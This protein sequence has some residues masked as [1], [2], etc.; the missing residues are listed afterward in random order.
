MASKLQEWVIGIVTPVAEAAVTAAI[1]DLKTEIAADIENVEAAILAKLEA[2]PAELLGVAG[3]DVNALL[4]DVTGTT[5]EIAAAVHTNIIPLF[6]GLGID[7][8]SLAQQ[9][10]A[11]IKAA[12]P[13]PFKY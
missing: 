13:F 7:T 10:I 2:L 5:D 8:N 12:I 1:A 9:L 3:T 11:A 6:S 4:R